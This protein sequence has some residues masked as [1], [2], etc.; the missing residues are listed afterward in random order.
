[1]RGRMHATLPAA[2]APT[3]FCALHR[4]L[5]APDVHMTPWSFTACSDSTPLADNTIDAA[6]FDK[7]LHRDTRYPTSTLLS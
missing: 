6:T 7:P 5:P 3:A 2:S 4:A 1:M